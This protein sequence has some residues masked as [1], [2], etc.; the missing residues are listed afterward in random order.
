MLQKVAWRGLTTHAR[1]YSSKA[2]RA[3]PTLPD[4]TVDTF[5]RYAFEPAV[6]A[7]LPK[8]SQVEMPAVT[9]WFTSMSAGRQASALSVSH[10]TMWRS[11]RLPIEITNNG[12]FARIEST[13]GFFLDFV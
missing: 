2:I 1:G 10:L 7:L 12:E 11:L 5:R 9:K 3:V 4:A 6:P 8:G 13:L